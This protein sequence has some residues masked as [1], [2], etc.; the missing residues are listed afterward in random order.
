MSIATSVEA[1]SAFFIGIE[2][3]KSGVFATPVSAPSVS[4]NGASDFAPASFKTSDSLGPDHS[5]FP[6]P[7]R[8][9]WMPGT[10]GR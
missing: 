8:I 2:R 3:T 1:S 5:A 9:H 4:I 10:R 6:T 7:P